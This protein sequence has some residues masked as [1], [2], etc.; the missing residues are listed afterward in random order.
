[1]LK[2]VPLLSGSV[3]FG[4][5]KPDEPYRHFVVESYRPQST[6]GLHGPVHIRPTSGQGIPVG[7]QVECAKRLTRDYPV[8]TKFRLLA[9]L[10][11]REDGGEYLYSYHGW[12]VEV[13][14]P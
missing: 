8:G 1:M 13:L 2:V 6:A 3:N 11:D 5:E 14:P 12:R 9:K 4:K 7:L 10:T